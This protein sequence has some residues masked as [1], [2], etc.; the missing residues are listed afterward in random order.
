MWQEAASRL[1]NRSYH[2]QVRKVA[3]LLARP[4]SGGWQPLRMSKANFVERKGE[5]RRIPLPRTRVNKGKKKGQGCQTRLWPVAY[6]QHEP[7]PEC[8]L[9]R[10]SPR[11]AFGRPTA[12]SPKQSSRFARFVDRPIRPSQNGRCARFVLSHPRLGSHRASRATQMEVQTERF[13]SSGLPAS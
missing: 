12:A 4:L 11:F 9:V 8:T 1:L 10:P 6:R 5:V 2:F 13:T 3:S 7:H